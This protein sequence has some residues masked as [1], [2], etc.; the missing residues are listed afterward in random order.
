VSK[1]WS[2]FK[3][4]PPLATALSPLWLLFFPFPDLSHRDGS[5]QPPRNPSPFFLLTS[6]RALPC[7]PVRRCVCVHCLFLALFFF[8]HVVCV[9]DSGENFF[10]PSI[11][12]GDRL[13]SGPTFDLAAVFPLI[14]GFF[15]A[16]NLRPSFVFFPVTSLQVFFGPSLP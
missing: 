11:S 3:T 4:P 1:P 9:L 15:D 5:E 12:T 6:S 8:Y 13:P 7:G 10:D 2:C 16:V 14:V